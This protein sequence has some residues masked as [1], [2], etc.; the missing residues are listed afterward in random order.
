LVELEKIKAET[1]NLESTAGNWLKAF[2]ELL[3]EGLKA[4]A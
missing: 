1:S 2:I 4:V 3:T